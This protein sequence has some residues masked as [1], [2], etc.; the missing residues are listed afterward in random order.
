[1]RF[2]K[3]RSYAKINISLGVLKKL[4]TKHHK[5]ESLV[6]LIDLY[7]QIYIKKIKGNGHKILFDGEFSN[8]INKKNTV[9]NLIQ[10][11]DQKKLL[12]NE[13]YLIK[14]R[15]NIPLKSG[16]GGGS[17]NAASILKYLI[18]KNNIKLKRNDIFKISSKIGSD[19]IL[20]LNKSS[21]ISKELRIKYAK[22][23]SPLHLII[24]KPDFGCSTK[25]I[26]SKV[27]NFSR[28]KL[29]LKSK[30]FLSVKFLSKLT[31]DLENPAFQKYPK[32]KNIKFSKS[33]LERCRFE[34]KIKSKR[35]VEQGKKLNEIHTFF[36]WS[37]SDFNVI[38]SFFH[39]FFESYSYL[40]ASMSN[41]Y[42]V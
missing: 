31:N 10:I 11:L 9:S 27:K 35:R 24:I 42:H 7:D 26:Y 20:G 12:N 22:L 30:K 37:T 3:I 19:T 2:D 17:M 38:S 34:K 39:I 40:F 21:I 25:D 6:S 4:K 32:L 18:K 36:S 41:C 1:M 33:T 5:I 16:L 15:K 28:T 13:K 8:G 23:K 14:I 29:K